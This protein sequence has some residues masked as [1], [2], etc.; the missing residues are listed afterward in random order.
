MEWIS[1]NDRKPDAGHEVLLYNKNW[2]Q[3]DYNPKG[4]RIGYL[5]DVSGWVSAYWCSYHDD[6]HTRNSA[7]D[8]KRFTD[9][10]A[11]N[12]V[13]THWMEIKPYVC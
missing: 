2:I 9:F 7:Q 12:Q 11:A 3:E 5:D 8:D 1:L 13:P 10:K 6:Y 4:V